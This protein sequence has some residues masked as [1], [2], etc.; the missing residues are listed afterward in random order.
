MGG[1]A[2]RVTKMAVLMFGLS[3]HT[4]CCMENGL[5]GKQ[6]EL[7]NDLCELQ[8]SASEKTP[9]QKAIEEKDG[10]LIWLLLKAEAKKKMMMNKN[11]L[12]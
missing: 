1:G 12:E 7:Q 6:C 9:L 2:M 3:A 5:K 11:E 4:L 10:K 8:G